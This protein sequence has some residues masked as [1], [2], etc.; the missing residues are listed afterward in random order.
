[1]KPAYIAAGAAVA[2]FAALL[3]ASSYA[4]ASLQY[5]S[6]GAQGFN[7]SDSTTDIAMDVCNPTSF[8]AGFD[9]LE[10]VAFYS[11]SQFADMEFEDTE[12][13]ANSQAV[14][15]GTLDV[16][17]RAALATVFQAFADSLNGR[18]VEEDDIRIRMTSE[19]RLLGFV[20]VTQSKE[21][22]GDE[23]SEMMNGSSFDCGD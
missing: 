1:M 22:S 3:A 2:I 16:D 10:F 14:A 18:D 21:M 5:R 7:F 23:F 13:P 15:D 8:P 17:G 20:P 6:R 12:V 4:N 9:R 19:F 11:E